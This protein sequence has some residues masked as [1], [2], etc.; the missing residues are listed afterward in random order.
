M[1]SSARRALR[2]VLLGAVLYGAMFV[3]VWLVSQ[4]DERAVA[5]AIVVL[6]AAHYNGRP[7]AVLRARLDHAALLYQ[8]GRAPVVIVTGGMADGD[9]VSEATVSQRYL[10]SR[11][12]PASAVVVQPVGRNTRESVASASEWLGDRGLETVLLVSDP[13]HMARLDA[14]A[15]AHGLVPYTSPT[16]TSPITEGEEWRRLASEAVKVPVVWVRAL[17]GGW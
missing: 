15:R 6:G 2:F 4:R 5:D 17:S 12:V 7:S 8:L 11:G 13:F 9:R 3:Y 14:E 16:H 1:T 10:V